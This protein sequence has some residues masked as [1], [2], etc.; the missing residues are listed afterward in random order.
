MEHQNFQNINYNPEITEFV[1]F[2]DPRT[3]EP[4]NRATQPSDKPSVGKHIFAIDS[5]QR[6]YT[7]FPNPNEYEILIPERYRN[8]TSIELKAAILPRTEYNI[9][10]CNK[11]LDLNIGDFISNVIINKHDVYYINP[12]NNNRMLPPN[13]T[14]SFMIES[15]KTADITCDIKNGRIISISIIKAGSGYDYTR[16]P[17]LYLYID[18]NGRSEQMNIDCST[19]VGLEITSELREGQYVIGGNPE[20]YVR[21]N[22]RD[23]RYAAQDQSS[24]PVDSPIQSWVPFNLLKELEAGISNSIL[25]ADVM[26]QNKSNTELVRHC[27]N[28]KSVFQ[29][30][31]NTETK[32]LPSWNDDYPLLFSSRIFSQYPVLENYTDSYI[33]YNP[34]NFD[35][36]S[37]RFNR[38]NLSNNLMLCIESNN[39]PSN[40]FTNNN[41]IFYNNV[42]NDYSYEFEILSYHL[43]PQLSHENQTWIICLNLIDK[44]ITKIDGTIGTLSQRSNFLG[45]NI[46]ASGYIDIQ[47]I[48]EDLNENLNSDITNIKVM[49]YGIKLAS[50]QNQIVNIATILGFDKLN[51]NINIKN[52]N[53]LNGLYTKT[54][55][56]QTAS[57]L[58]QTGIGPFQFGVE[59]PA[60]QISGL[61]YKTEHDYCM[62]GDPEYVIMS[63]RARHGNG[64]SIPGINDRVESQNS[65]NLD[66]VFA[67]LIYDSTV[68]S[69]LQEMSSGN[70]S[71]PI[72]NSSGAQQNA[73]C[74]TYLMNNESSEEINTVQ[75]GGNTGMQ[76]TPYQKH[77]GNLKAM[78]G[79]DFD[80]KLIEFPQP[81]AQIHKMSL[82]FSKFTKWSQGSREELYDFHGK[83]HLLLFE[84]TCSDFMT[85]KRF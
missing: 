14:Y 10:S 63:F 30:S 48:K 11:Y 17:K 27:Y 84:I 22:G 13:G 26:K 31:F 44:P 39:L 12:F 1:H 40:Y 70:N 67:C 65:T 2:P 58:G 66:R 45:F 72:I 42:E 59:K 24:V 8:V 77:P 53:N 50:G 38:I 78:K 23:A 47:N 32:H 43:A 75:L 79:T 73:N 74:T 56:I 33:N 82:R 62:I 85:G 46:N 28:R 49:Q 81:V 41:K 35:A 6:D 51:Y 29:T 19:V 20:L 64:S 55:N 4:F 60:L 37:C 9:N 7:F 16:P 80:K 83:E 25:N 54:I 5:R 15:N 69:V 52:N 36:N 61:T 57:S 76:N 34:D 21:N 18:I 68:P 3:N 71:S